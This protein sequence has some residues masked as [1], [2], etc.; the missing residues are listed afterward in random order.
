MQTPAAQRQTG[1]SAA[2]VSAAGFFR[3]FFGAPESPLNIAVFRIVL[4]FFLTRIG[5][6]NISWFASLPPALRVPPP[7]YESWFHLIPLEPEFARA[8]KALFIAASWSACLG[9]FTRTS[10]FIAFAAGLYVLGVP[11]FFGKINHG[12]HLLWFALITAASRSGDVLS[13]DAV[14][15][16]AAAALRGKV[17]HPS[18]APHYG[19]PLRF[20]WI[21]IG[22]IYFFPGYWKL[23]AAGAAWIFSDNLKYILQNMWAAGGF[24]PFFRIDRYP[25]LY[26]GAAFCV[27][28]FELSVIL[29]VF[30]RRLHPLVIAGGTFFHYMAYKFMRIGFFTLV[31][32][33]A[34][35]V[36]WAAL[37]R[38]AGRLMAREN[39]TVLFPEKA[40]G[41]AFLLGLLGGMD[42]LGRLRFRAV[43]GS[44]PV[45]FMGDEKILYGRKRRDALARRLPL[46]WPLYFV[47]LLVPSSSGDA[48]R[49]AP[50]P[51]PGGTEAGISP[52]RGRAPLLVSAAGIFWIVS[53]LF[54]GFT[55][56]DSWPVGYYP[57]FSYI[58]RPW[59]TQ[60]ALTYKSEGEK[61]SAY[62]TG[63]LRD[64]FHLSR[65]QRV[66]SRLMYE[67][68]GEGRFALCQALA[69]LV[70][71]ADGELA[72][73][74]GV[75]RIYRQKR[76]TGPDRA[77]EAPFGRQLLCEM[78]SQNRA[79]RRYG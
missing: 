31:V 5:S 21:L 42:F 61:E 2:S 60:I 62:D 13:I 67:K 1:N 22:L 47:S 32:C 64:R 73:K 75:L 26:K 40:R 58:A 46:L 51:A 66:E 76:W 9:F 72:G 78:D 50:H 28:F 44:G 33:Y 17:Y 56:F 71:K 20:I 74:P 65:W 10:A 79:R 14:L 57:T 35:F 15:R 69:D 77:A 3:R 11:N 7:G 6:Y 52:A 41:M 43:P 29:L 34:I 38:S 59:L 23:K 12:H 37:L 18:D 54:C 19:L 49:N 30:F 8:V 63:K 36:N 24:E 25:A 45:L 48:S 27:V 70:F 39:V 53:A 4:F 55:R 16:A 68:T